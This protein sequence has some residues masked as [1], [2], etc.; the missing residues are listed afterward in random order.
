MSKD[1]RAVSYYMPLFFK[2]GKGGKIKKK[3]KKKKRALV[4]TSEIFDNS[5]FTSEIF[6][7]LC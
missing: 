5:I 1:A 2:K 6:R 3:K 7:F 4:S